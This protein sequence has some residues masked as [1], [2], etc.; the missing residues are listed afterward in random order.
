M[1]AYLDSTTGAP[2][3]VHDKMFRRPEIKA[4]N[5]MMMTTAN[6]AAECEVEECALQ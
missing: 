4:Q 3:R 1:I 2:N 6:P 5:D